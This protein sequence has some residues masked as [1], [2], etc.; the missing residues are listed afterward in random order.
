MIVLIIVHLLILRVS[1]FKIT[2]SI[3][4]FYIVLSKLQRDIPEFQNLTKVNFYLVERSDT[5]ELLPQ[6]RCITCSPGT[7]PSPDKSLCVPCNIFPI[8]GIEK[9]K[10]LS[11]EGIENTK[12][13]CEQNSQC[14]SIEGGICIPPNLAVKLPSII[15]VKIKHSLNQYF[16]MLIKALHQNLL[17][18][19]SSSLLLFFHSQTDQNGSHI[20]VLEDNFNRHFSRNG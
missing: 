4:I 7:Q 13:S 10:P 3:Q 19:A 12:E 18:A 6:I 9:S 14:A 17:K 2:F 16:K 1:A 20:K 15:Q 5:G 11:D 8:L